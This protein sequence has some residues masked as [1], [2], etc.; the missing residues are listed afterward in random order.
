M[1][2]AGTSLT[3]RPGDAVRL[4]TTVGLRAAGPITAVLSLLDQAPW[5]FLSSA[6]L[7]VDLAEGQAEAAGHIDLFIGPMT[8]AELD[9]DIAA[10]LSEVESD[11]VVPGHRLE[12]RS[13]AVAA[14]PAGLEIG[15]RLQVDS[16]SMEATWRQSFMPAELGRST[17]EAKIG[18]TPDVLREFGITLPEGSIAGEGT[19]ELRLDLVPGQPPSFVFR[20]ALEGLSLSL[21]QIG[22]SKGAS[23]PGEVVVEGALSSPPRID[24]LSL[25]AADLSAEGD[26]RLTRDGSLDRLQLSRVQ[27]G[28]WLDASVTL[29]TQPGSDTP[30]VTVE[31][32][33]VNLGAADFGNGGT[34]EGGSIGVSL[35]RLQ[36]TDSIAL[37]NFTADLSTVAGLE[38]SFSG[39]VNGGP[40]VVG[41]VTPQAGR[42]AARVQGDDA[43]AVFRA[44]DLFTRA[45]GG[46][47]DLLLLPVGP[48]SYTGELWI[49][50]IKVRDAPVLASLLNAASGVGLLQQLGGQGIAFDQVSAEFRVDPAAVTVARSSAV[51][52]GLGLSLDGVYDTERTLMNFQ[53]VVS[54]LYLVN[55]IGAI[56]TRPG[57]G[58]LGV[59]FTLSGDPSDPEVGVNPLSVL[60]PGMF[61]EIFRREVPAIED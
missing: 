54:P 10:R 28:N 36:I 58:L 3:I 6:G 1:N 27:I 13:L 21:P 32:G 24:R 31:G 30:A 22:W 12:A 57:E 23:R 4:P 18:I 56:L 19:G 49:T 50:D 2:A 11:Q 53:G 45:E 29:T 41:R 25:V 44:A 48:E 33:S 26:L 46:S 35:D 42:V 8:E 40:F 52:A 60:T 39:Q 5:R 55:G 61:R 38:G 51:G 47:L 34:G 16:A 43:G 15:G 59:N 7:P 17:V 9:Y 37:T 14:T 20:S